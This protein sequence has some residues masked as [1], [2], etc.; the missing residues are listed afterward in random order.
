MATSNK[1]K[2]R[3]TEGH[4][5]TTAFKAGNCWALTLNPDPE[6]LFPYPTYKACGAELT[7]IQ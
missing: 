3:C 5:M 7:P 6:K 2:Y 1:I 4:S